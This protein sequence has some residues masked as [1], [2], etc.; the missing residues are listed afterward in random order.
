MAEFVMPS[1]GA[2]MEHGVLVEWHVNPGDTVSRGDVIAEVETAKGV[3]EVEVFE[4]GVV[5]ELLFSPSEEEIPVGT[6][7]ARIRTDEAEPVAAGAPPAP[8]PKPEPAGAP[9]PMDHHAVARQEAEEAGERVRISPVAQ[10]MADKLGVDVSTIEGSG[11]R[12]AIRKADVER[13]AEQRKAETQAEKKPAKAPKP[14]KEKAAK[15][16]QSIRQG[17]A[18]AM[19]RSNREIPHY[20]LE[21][22]ID[23]TH[24][25]RWLEAENQQR[26][27]K[28][29]LLMTVVLLK[30]VA[31]A[32]EAVPTLNA[33][34]QDDQH[35]LQ[36]AIHIGVGI[37]LRKGGLI[38]P[39]IHH[40]DQKNMDELMA[41][42]RDLI[43][44][45]RSGGLRGSEMTDGTITVTNLG[46]LGVK[47]VYGIIYPP[48]VALVGFGKIMDMPWAE[49]GLLGV[50]PVLTATIAG[51]HR[52]TDGRTGAQFLDALNRCLQEVETL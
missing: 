27:I 46:D 3:I 12:G 8:P 14:D 30:A 4:D 11:P 52:A 42:L 34:W 1:L 6:P 51:D 50:R 7:M 25:I 9:H 18:M 41:A 40:V 13:A 23:M 28:D 24:A 31:R 21:T 37:A 32:L 29:R 22:P 15:F 10:R 16:Q 49:N 19:S 38:A 47:K 45:T 33:Y 5:E 43:A 26:S 20:Y 44:R 17:I 35:Q 48:Q 36:E 39:A 2:D